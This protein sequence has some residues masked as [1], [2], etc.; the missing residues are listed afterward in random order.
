MSKYVR[1]RRNVGDGLPSDPEAA[2]GDRSNGHT[3]DCSAS[4]RQAAAGVLL[5][6]AGAYTVY[7]FLPASPAA[8]EV[9]I[10]RHAA[11]QV[12]YSRAEPPLARDLPASPQETALQALPLL[13]SGPEEA[14]RIASRARDP[15]IGAHV[16]GADGPTS[17]PRPAAP[18]TAAPSPHLEWRRH[19]LQ[20]DDGL[21]DGPDIP[22]QEPPTKADSVVRV[23]CDTTTGPLAIE[24]HR[25]WAPQ[26]ARRFLDMVKEGFFS[27]KVALFRSVKGFLC[28][29]GVAGDPSIH[30]AWEAKGPIEDDP[31]WLD[32]E[33]ERR[34][35][36]GYLSF[37]GGGANSRGV[38]FFFTYRDTSLGGSSWEVPFAKLV[39][40]ESFQSMDH[41]YTGYG[42]MAA[43]GG[44]APD[45]ARMYRVGL[46]YLEGSF[47]DIDYIIACR[48][49]EG[50][51]EGG[52]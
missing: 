40:H 5:L 35:K 48:V 32:Q 10:A 3:G 1:A 16:H 42:D 26:G 11:P 20:Q 13:T 38:E 52:G 19:P 41:W 43:F 47:P 24:V 8:A 31:Q 15:S 50:E 4:T 39:G 28:Q 25:E 27:T 46:Q 21:P 23:H 17:P 2:R 29:T 18:A 30:A 14:P 45:Q 33:D 37:A 22:G 34:M 44:H 51:S 7:L 9:A 49:V 6:L 12:M 36:R